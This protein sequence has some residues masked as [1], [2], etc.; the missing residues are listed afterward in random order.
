M[1][2]GVLDRQRRQL[3]LLATTERGIAVDQ[4][5]D[6][7]LHRGAV[8]MM[9]CWVNTSTWSSSLTCSK[10]AR[11]PFAQVE[12]LGDLRRHCLFQL[13]GIGQYLHRQRQRERTNLLQ[14][15]PSTSTNTLRSTS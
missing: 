5:L 8:G 4:L 3:G 10:R 11:S 7:Q 1:H 6:H 12:E 14:Q 2:V 9:W 15:R 13:P